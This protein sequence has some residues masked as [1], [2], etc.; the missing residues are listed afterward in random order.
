ML[1]LV[2]WISFSYV[3]KRKVVIPHIMDIIEVALI[4][5]VLKI[6]TIDLAFSGVSS[7]RGQDIKT[8]LATNPFLSTLFV[9]FIGPVMEE[10]IYRS[11]AAMARY[12]N[13]MP[14]YSLAVGM[15]SAIIFGFGHEAGFF[16]CVFV[17]SGLAY[18]WIAYRYGLRY[19]IFA[20]VMNNTLVIFYATIG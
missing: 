14:V 8:L 18:W 11:G 15:V 19:S 6:A 5:L 16:G 17:V 9:C 4:L 1:H 3:E 20:H 2:N 10:V 12:G 7:D 13:L